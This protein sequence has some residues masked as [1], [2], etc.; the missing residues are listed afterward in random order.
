MCTIADDSGDNEHEATPLIKPTSDPD[1]STSSVN[2]MMKTTINSYSIKN[3]KKW[4]QHKIFNFFK[5]FCI[6]GVIVVR[7]V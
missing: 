6:P 5:A 1:I 3:S 7:C 2:M 4:M